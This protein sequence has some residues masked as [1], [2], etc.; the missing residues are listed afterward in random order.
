MKESLKTRAEYNV[1][2]R[3]VKG[4]M[5]RH[6]GVTGM[7]INALIREKCGQICLNFA[8]LKL[9]VYFKSQF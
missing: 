2:S 7:E 1:K 5:F 3:K 8:K 6:H 9:S 4:K